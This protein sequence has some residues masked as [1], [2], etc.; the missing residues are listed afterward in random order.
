MKRI[1][2]TVQLSL[3]LFLVLVIPCVAL[4]TY[5]SHLISR[6]SEAEIARASLENIE[7]SRQL[8]EMKMSTV[9]SSVHQMA[10]YTDFS[11]LNLLN[12]FS[13]IRGNADNGLRVGKLQHELSKLI[14][15]DPVVISAFFLLDNADYVI[16]SDRGVVPLD[17]YPS[18]NWLRT[19]SAERR[20]IGGV[21]VP[22]TMQRASEN[23][24][25]RGIGDNTDI[26]VLSYV[27]PLSRL[28][29]ST[30]GTLVI[31]LLEREVYDSLNPNGREDHRYGTMLLQAN[32]RVMS[33][34]DPS[35]FLIQ[36]RNLPNIATILDTTQ[37]ESYAFYALND[38]PCLYTS[39]KSDYL[40]WVYVSIHP[41][42]GLRTQTQDTLRRVAVFTIIIVLVSTILAV[43]VS[44]RLFRPMR[45][46]VRSLKEAGAGQQG[47]ERN[48]LAFITSAFQGIRRQEAELGGLLQK[49]EQAALNLALY[50]TLTSDHVSD[51]EFAM[52]RLALPHPFYVVGMLTIDDYHSYRR[53]TGSDLRNYHLLLISAQS[54]ALL[55]GLCVARGIKYAGDRLAV[56]MNLET[57]GRPAEVFERLSSGLEALKQAAAGILVRRVF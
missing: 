3:V 25:Q 46:L 51:A 53:A 18:M 45:E 23:E 27:Y 1:P 13:S 34:P 26:Q 21:W 15:T 9:S 44:M 32:G 16:S 7:T 54:E 6:S 35:N 56:V 39:L 48:E 29:T 30:S 2:L 20:G 19:V 4:T 5:S 22:R 50:N 38:V 43:V 33:H 14:R 31:N 57:A 8:T 49:H 40:G 42:T 24:L 11:G 17:E 28:T 10:A 55:E 36:S 12:R 37:T 52:V 47:M 41:M